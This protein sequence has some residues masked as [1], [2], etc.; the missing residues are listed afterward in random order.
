MSTID[1]RLRRPAVVVTL[2]VIMTVLDTTIVN[3]AVTTLGTDLDASLSAVQWVLTGYTLALSMAI[4]LTG[5]SVR[6]F[7]QR[8]MWLVSLALFIGGSLL[9][10]LAWS[11]PAL[12]AFRVVQGFGGGMLMPVGQM[13]LAREAGP[14]RVGRVMAIM[15]VPAMLAP[16]LGPV[17]GGLIVDHLSWRW[18]FYINIPFCAVALVAALRMLPRDTERD[19]G[20]RLDALG[21]ALLSPGLA[22]LVYGLS[23]A[24]DGA[25][26]ARSSAFAG[27]GAVLV[28][29]FA[30]HAL[31]KGDGALVDLRPLRSRAFTAAT[32]GLF[33]YSGAAFGLMVLIPLLAQV[34]RQ[35]TPVR[36]GLLLAPLGLGAMITM[37]VAGRLADRYGA[38]WPAV[39]GMLVALCG[40]LGLTTVEPGTGEPLIMAAV[41]VAGVGHGAITP[42]LMAAAYQG[43]P[44]TSVPAATTAA[45]ILIRVGSA[46][47][48]A[49]LT[50][51]L[52]RSL[53]D[54][55]PGASGTL[56]EVA[57][58]ASRLP[59]APA[60]LTDAFTHT[61]WWAP[62][63][64]AVA[65]VPVAVLP[66]RKDAPQ[67]KV[68]PEKPHARK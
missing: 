61:L 35:E 43:L 50:V 36:A 41:L 65:L 19:A 4:P 68:V 34:A 16:V 5:W 14:D 31:R 7:G 6:R 30:V 17:V 56:E 32:G 57:A 48:T 54:E 20:A 67:A 25:G 59:D 63:I 40:M 29:A 8:T 49:A 66:R 44:R 2:G 37:P 1:A 28:A 21:L 9:S 13:M 47:G 42:P 62:A 3:V 46:F 39:G 27:G 26:P 38:R 10:G 22:L 52:Q 23:E 51:I 33:L 11:V 15:S 58:Q 55:I 18:M 60:L 53:Q 12:V 45:N 24:G 64:V